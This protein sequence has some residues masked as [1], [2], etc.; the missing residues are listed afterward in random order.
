MDLG[1]VPAAWHRVAGQLALR[2]RLL[3]ATLT[4]VA[5]VC[6]LTALRP[7]T[8]ATNRVW[9]AARDLPGGNPLAPADVVPERLPVVDVPAGALA[10]TSPVTG[11]LLAAPVRRGEP[12][13]DVRLLAPSLLAAV[14]P[15]DAVAVPVRVADAAA[16]AAL[17]RAGDL[18]DVLAAGDP[19]G[20]GPP[21]PTTVA[22]GVRVLAVPG[23]GD[24]DGGGLLVVAGTPG[25]AA[26]LAQAATGA[27]LSIDVRRQP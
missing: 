16:T 2:R 17:V 24:P 4:G 9:A 12:L 8:P 19:A 10:A 21:A 20:G 15:A 6:G 1:E 22:R 27:R 14:G 26:A 5:V 7:S 3:V 13:T 23:H 25:Q 11:R 18:V